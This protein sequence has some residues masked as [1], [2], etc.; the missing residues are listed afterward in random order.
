LRTEAHIVIRLLLLLLLLFSSSLLSGT[1]S[2]SSS[3][4]SSGGSRTSRTNVHEET[5]EVLTGESLGIEGEPDG[6]N[7]NTSS[8]D[9][10]G[11]LV[12]LRRKSR[13]ISFM[14]AV[15]W[16]K[17]FRNAN[18][19]EFRNG[20]FIEFNTHGDLN[21][22]I[23]EDEGSVDDGEF[24]R[25]CLVTKAKGGSHW[26]DGWMCLLNPRVNAWSGHMFCLAD[27]D[28]GGKIRSGFL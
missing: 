6:L 14:L 18:G 10:G 24:G 2:G 16:R 12:S 11:K 19:E 22:V 3:T 8:L 5:S 28:F 4:T 13:E 1:T 27:F 23:L 17:K 20:P 7:L 9:K 25:H 15:L 21:T 26:M